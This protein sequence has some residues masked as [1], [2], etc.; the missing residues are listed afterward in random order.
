MQSI[1]DDCLVEKAKELLSEKT[2]CQKCNGS[3]W[4][5]REELSREEYDKDY[6]CDDTK[7]IC[8]ECLGNGTV[9][10]NK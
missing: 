10:T 9:A 4:V 6:F 5:W 2:K 1:S 7:Y 8:D 3:G